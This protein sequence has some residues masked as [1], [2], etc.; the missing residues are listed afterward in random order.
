[1]ISTDNAK[2]AELAAHL[3]DALG[4]LSGRIVT[5]INPRARRISLRLDAKSGQVVL[6]RPRG[7]SARAA[8]RFAVEKRSW[9][10]SRLESL[11]PRIPFRD[12]VSVPYLGAAHVIRHAP[13]ARRG[14]WRENG[15]IFV[16]G[17]E[18]HMARRVTDWF[19]EEAK[20]LLGP[21]T[22][23]MADS[24]GCKVARISVRDTRSRWGSCSADGNL[25]FSWRLIL[26]PEAVLTYVAAHE[27]AHLRHLDHS[28]AFWRTVGDAL[29]GYVDQHAVAE[30]MT[31]KSAREWLRRSGTALHAYG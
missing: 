14:V 17:R 11:P 5:S 28:R 16:S 2:A 12:G 15:V 13:E 25:S 23:C 20:R 10:E 9:I 7:V 22:R 3:K 6:V 31:P 18:E 1:M 27:V 26:A 4:E 30:I 8:T 19:K 21:K 24:L 29:A